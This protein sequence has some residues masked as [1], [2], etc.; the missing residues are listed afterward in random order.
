MKF[1]TALEGGE[2]SRQIIFHDIKHG[3]ACSL[4]IFL[5][6]FLNA[7]ANVPISTTLPVREVS[8]NPSTVRS[9]WTCSVST[10]NLNRRL[11]WLCCKDELESNLGK[12]RSV[13]E[14]KQERRGQNFVTR[15]MNVRSTVTGSSKPLAFQRSTQQPHLRIGTQ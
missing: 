11:K 9:E 1:I 13:K 10:A 7:E 5:S 4:S 3:Y 8:R 2:R 15:A 12:R 14:G 6:L